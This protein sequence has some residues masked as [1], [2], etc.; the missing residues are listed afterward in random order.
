[1]SGSYPQN[2]EEALE[3]DELIETAVE[4]LNSA[5]Q[6]ADPETK[7]S[8]REAWAAG[9]LKILVSFFSQKISLANG[10]M[11]VGG[12]LS[13]ADIYTYAMIN[14]IVKGTYDYVPVDYLSA[15][16]NMASYI[17]MMEANPTFAPYKL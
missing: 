5:P 10:G 17:A 7:K 3:V 14:G 15:W 1:M 9:K 13:L 6:H 4:V 8:L 12:K 16:P 2:P 11:L